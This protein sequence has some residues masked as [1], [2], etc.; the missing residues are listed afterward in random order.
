MSYIRFHDLKIMSLLQIDHRNEYREF[1]LF[2]QLLA[3]LDM[4]GKD[5]DFFSNLCALTIFTTCESIII[6]SCKTF[7]T[8]NSHIIKL[9][10]QP[11][12]LLMKEC[13]CKN[14]DIFYMY[15][16]ILSRHVYSDQ[17]KTEEKNLVTLSLYCILDL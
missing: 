15:N 3:L 16:R 4:P 1:C 9:S 7:F 11:T 14:H 5:L 12:V 10:K 6:T 8:H 2:F 17:E 13:P